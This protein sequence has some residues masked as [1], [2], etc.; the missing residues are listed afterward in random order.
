MERKRTGDESAVCSRGSRR[1]SILPLRGISPNSRKGPR[2][3]G[4]GAPFTKLVSITLVLL[5]GI[6]FVAKFGGPSILRLYIESG[7]GSCEKIPI[8]CMQP[9]KE[10]I[11]LG[12]NKEYLTELRPYESPKMSVAIP[13]D[14]TVVQEMMKKV[15]YK[16]GKHQHTGNVIYLLHKEP[17]F[18]INLFPRL[19]KQGINDDY[20]F[21]K[22][23]MFA[24]SN[25][26]KNLTDAFFVIMKGVFIPDLGDL[27]N[28][29]MAEFLIADK[30]GFINY[31]LGGLENYFDCNIIDQQG[32]FFKIYIKDK[33]A[34]LNLEK[35]LTIISTVNK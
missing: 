13:R 23:T 31:N 17:K 30:Y 26:M 14:F 25:A 21:I 32:N 5:L 16:K 22:R 35:V 27:K 11:G 29:T 28:V 6:L 1:H 8:L 34:S 12:V 33:G 2:P 18:F 7:V 20:E 15:Y 24:N 19:G 10:I 9:D 3:S 4:R